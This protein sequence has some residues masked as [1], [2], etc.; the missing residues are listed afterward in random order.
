MS[1]NVKHGN[2][3]TDAHSALASDGVAQTSTIAGN[4]EQA[5]D[6]SYWRAWDG[7]LYPQKELHEYYGPDVGEA[8]RQNAQDDSLMSSLLRG[9][10]KYIAVQPSLVSKGAARPSSLPGPAELSSSIQSANDASELTEDTSLSSAAQPVQLSLRPRATPVL[11]TAALMQKQVQDYL[12]RNKPGR[13]E[14]YA[15]NGKLVC[16]AGIARERETSQHQ[17]GLP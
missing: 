9:G 2:L 16:P 6:K 11:T 15:L 3:S 1:R 10:L 8:H 5:A 13:I 4:A 14:A 7:R 12:A 17:R